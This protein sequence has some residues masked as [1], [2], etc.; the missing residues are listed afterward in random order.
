MRCVWMANLVCETGM[1]VAKIKIGRLSVS[2]QV[3]G[4][5]IATEKVEILHTGKI[6]GDV[7]T[8]LLVVEEGAILEGKCSMI[9]SEPAAT[10]K[11]PAAKVPGDNPSKS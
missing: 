2:G 7:T 11:T 8:P 5:I 9:K 3:E 6:I 10:A 4:S 1:I